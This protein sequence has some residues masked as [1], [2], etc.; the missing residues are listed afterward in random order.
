METF[1]VALLFNTVTEL[2]N[3]LV[4]IAVVRRRLR[5]PK[6]LI[7]LL[8]ALL[9]LVRMSTMTLIGIIL[10]R[11]SV[12]CI[13]GAY[14]VGLASVLFGQSLGPHQA[15]A[16]PTRRPAFAL[17]QTLQGILAVIVLDM[18]LSMD[19]LLIGAEWLPDGIW[20]YVNIA[21]GLVIAFGTVWWLPE[22]LWRS[23]WVT[24]VAAV[25]VGLA[26]WDLLPDICRMPF[27]A[28]G[29]IVLLFILARRFWHAACRNRSK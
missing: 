10:D 3:A 16:R 4:L 20:G 11:P 2:D 13:I 14:A 29:G 6:A 9:A 17:W 15:I 19:Q 21:L 5:L 26:G 12:R 1:W 24:R 18:A 23:P 27:A 25:L 28:F 22:R 8:L 7:V